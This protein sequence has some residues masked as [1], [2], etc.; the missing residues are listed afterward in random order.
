MLSEQLKRP[1]LIGQ[2]DFHTVARFPDTQYRSPL[3]SAELFG[4]DKAHRTVRRDL[5]IVCATRKADSGKFLQNTI[6]CDFGALL[7][8]FA[9][10]LYFFLNV[11][12]RYQL[13]ANVRVSVTGAC[14]SLCSI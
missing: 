7:Q 5:R 2:L 12:F 1:N 14:S 4:G 3:L 8:I 11:I 9:S 10:P 13:P 6:L